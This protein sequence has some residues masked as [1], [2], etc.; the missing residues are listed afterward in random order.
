MGGYIGVCSSR[1]CKICTAEV[2]LLIYCGVKRFLFRYMNIHRSKFPLET[3][4]KATRRI[5]VVT[6]QRLGKQGI[7]RELISFIRYS[8]S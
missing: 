2:F 5:L 3:F 6:S 8:K 4:P 7:L 1:N